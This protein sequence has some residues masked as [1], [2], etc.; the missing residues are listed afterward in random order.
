LLVIDMDTNGGLVDS[1]I[2]I[3]EILNKFK[4]QTVTFVNRKAFSAGAFIAV[5]T[6]KIFMAPQSVIGAAAPILLSPGGAGVEKMPDTMEVKMTSALRALVRTAAEKNGHNI[7]VVEAMIDKSKELKIDGEVLNEKGQILTLTDV[8]AA[9]THGSPPKVLLS[10]GTMESL[11][12]LLG[13]LGYAGAERRDIRPTGAEQIG[14]WLNAVSPLLLI[15]GIVGIYLEF[16]SPGFG[17]PGIIGLAAFALYFLGGY[18]AGLSGMEWVLVFLLGVALVAVELFLFPGT[19]VI[20]LLGAALML[21]ALIMALVDVYPSSAPAWPGLPALP[22]VTWDAFQRPLRVFGVALVGAVV[23]IAVLSRF[24]PKTPFYHTLVSQ[25]ASGMH[26][27]AAVEERRTTLLGQ[28]GV[29]LSI[30]RPGGKARFGDEILD[31][32]SEG[33]LVPKGS[34]VRIVGY[35]GTEAL[36]QVVAGRT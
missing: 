15:I 18:V 6:H 23:S 29:T 3:M 2:E 7:A 4:G 16:K 24:L 8:Q 10:A 28:E 13:Q 21:G 33:D 19:L 31:V 20:G 9:K 14:T 5:A 35:S 1:T 26:T 22:P 36:V 34:R 17:L 27:E 25:S 11:E 30:L 12:Q 32:I